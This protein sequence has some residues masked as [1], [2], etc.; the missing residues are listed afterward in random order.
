MK[1]KPPSEE[2][3]QIILAQWLDLRGLLYCHVPNEGKHKPQYHAKRKR[4]GVKK[5]FP[6]IAIFDPPTLPQ[7]GD[8]ASKYEYLHVCNSS[9][10][11]AIELKSKEGKPTQ[12][13]REWLT[14]L[15]VRKWATAICY[16]ADEA[17]ALLERLYPR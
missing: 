14:R 5:G 3:E 13:Q 12:E 2:Q 16:G 15:S 9:P 1:L 11:T 8:W 7:L 6:D 4:M 17:I 10:G